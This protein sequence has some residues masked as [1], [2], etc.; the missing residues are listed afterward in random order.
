MGDF[1][2]S[3]NSMTRQLRDAFQQLKDSKEEL[4]N[5]YN[6]LV[7]TRKAMLK[8]MEDLEEARNV[9]ESATKPRRIFSPI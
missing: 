8:I 5:Q 9:A 3:F 6:E 1:S 7:E 2:E 4:Q